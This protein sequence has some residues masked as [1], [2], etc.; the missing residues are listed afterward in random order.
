MKTVGKRDRRIV[1]K[2]WARLDILA[3]CGN[4]L[5]RPVADYLRDGVYELRLEYVGVNYRILYFFSGSECVVASHGLTKESRVP[6][7]EIDLA[8]RRKQRFESDPERF[9]YERED[10]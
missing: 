8:I 1:A 2:C 3:E 6:D 4:K 5:R 9:S 10:K 7:R